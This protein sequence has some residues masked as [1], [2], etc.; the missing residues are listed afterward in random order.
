MHDELEHEGIRYFVYKRE[1]SA[2]EYPQIELLH[3]ELAMI[4][5]FGLQD[6]YRGIARHPY[7]ADAFNAGFF[8]GMKP[9]YLLGKHSFE[10]DIH[11]A[12]Y[13]NIINDLET[14]EKARYLELI[15]NDAVMKR[16]A[17][18]LSIR[19]GHWSEAFH[20]ATEVEYNTELKQCTT[21]KDRMLAY[22]L[23]SILFQVL[24]VV[25][26]RDGHTIVNKDGSYDYH[27]GLEYNSTYSPNL[28]GI[29][30]RGMVLSNTSDLRIYNTD[31]E[32]RVSHKMIVP[33]IQMVD[34]SPS[35]QD[36]FYGIRGYRQ[37]ERFYDIHIRDLVI[38]MNNILSIWLS[39]EDFEYFTITNDRLQRAVGFLST[40]G[41]EK[42]MLATHSHGYTMEALKMF[43]GMPEKWVRS[44]TKGY[45]LSYREL[46][47]T[48]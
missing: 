37:N 4:A 48:L 43:D 18:Q 21:S 34:S 10:I 35:L 12:Y 28:L 5:R 25:E 20:Y 16:F 36:I 13:Q 29:M 42:A 26:E 19:Q 32:G 3:P 47:S 17:Q 33:L 31:S 7:V 24:K 22:Y 2:E 45:P 14:P 39:I 46:L 1:Y 9:Q 15:E 40:Y 6:S 23:M 8:F 38:I 41:F 27:L 30:L 11:P 44:I